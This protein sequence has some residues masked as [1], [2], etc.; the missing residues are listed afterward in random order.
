MAA[1][2]ATLGKGA[3]VFAAPGFDA[4]KFFS[5]LDQANPT[6]Y[7]AVPTMHQAILTRAKRNREVIDRADRDF[8]DAKVLYDEA[9]DLAKS[10]PI[11]NEKLRLAIDKTQSSA[12][13]YR[14]AEPLYSGSFPTGFGKKIQTLLQF[15]RLCRGSMSSQRTGERTLEAPSVLTL[16]EPH[17]TFEPP[18]AAAASWAYAEPLGPGQAAI[19]EGL[20]NPDAES[21]RIAVRL[22]SHPPAPLHL[23]GLMNTLKSETD[24][25]IIVQAGVSFATYRGPA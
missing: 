17:F 2:L 13:L 1:V 10:N 9:K 6:L 23:A 16:A 19:A 11:R 3:S 18:T 5:W 25:D 15:M 20:L 14:L 8:T 12:K 4:L 21:R 24:A 22:L 7:T